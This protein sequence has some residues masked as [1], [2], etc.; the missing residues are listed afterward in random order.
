MILDRVVWHTQE[1]GTMLREGTMLKDGTVLD[2]LEWSPITGLFV[3]RA[4]SDLNESCLD[5]V[6]AWR[7]L[8]FVKHKSPGWD[9]RPG[10]HTNFTT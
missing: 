9:V 2:H 6:D 7:G 5:A 4:L 10:W 8:L 1:D 3:C